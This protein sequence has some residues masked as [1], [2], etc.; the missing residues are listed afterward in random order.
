MDEV[1]PES[2]QS[3]V[4]PHKLQHEVVSAFGEVEPAQQQ[5]FASGDFD[6]HV[7]VVV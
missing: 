3:L 6:E 1:Q 2:R 4:L 7:A 5:A